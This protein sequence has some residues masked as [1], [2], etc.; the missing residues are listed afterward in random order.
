MDARVTDEPPLRMPPTALAINLAVIRAILLRDVQLLTG[1]YGFGVMLLLLM[2]LCHLLVVLTIFHVLNRV[3][4]Q[5]GDQ[6]LY[7]G[8][9]ILPFVIFV[10]MARQIILSVTINRAL[11][12]FSR[13]K[14]FDILIARSVLEFVNAT[15][16]CILILALLILFSSEFRPYDW[17]GMLFAIAA[18]IYLAFCVGVA[19]ALITH[20]IPMWPIVFNLSAPILWGAS[21]IVFV[22]SAIPAP[23]NQWLALNP[24]LQCIEWLRSSYYEGY[25]SE[26]INVPYLLT[27]STAT[28]AISLIAER[29]G[30]RMFRI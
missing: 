11:L 18:T 16:V 19:H 20:L 8:L 10:Y 25:P 29:F 27:L 4:P 5:S 30:R 1:K 6:I 22:P 26:L 17:T 2:P 14:I 15:V 3:T 21:G 12:Y 9:S 13:V 28:L 23:Y 7:Y 24:L